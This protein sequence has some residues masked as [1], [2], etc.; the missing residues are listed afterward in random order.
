MT[1][2]HNNI[3]SE[4]DFDWLV[5]HLGL[6]SSLRADI[7]SSTNILVFKQLLELFSCDWFLFQMSRCLSPL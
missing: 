6:A 5:L 4:V 7:S 3:A 2:G 1:P